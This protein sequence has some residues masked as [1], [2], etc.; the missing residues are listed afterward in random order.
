[1]W[2]KLFGMIVVSALCVA[3]PAVAQ[4]WTEVGNAGD[5]PSTA[6]VLSGAGPLTTVNGQTSFLSDDVDM[7][8][9][10][11]QG[12]GTFSA[13]AQ[14]APF[15]GL[16]LDPTLALFDAEG[17]AVYANDNMFPPDP[18]IGGDAARLPANHA[19]TPLAP[20]LYYLAIFPSYRAPI[21]SFG[22]IF[23]CIPC[24]PGIVFGPTGPGGAGAITGWS[25]SPF[26]GGT[27]RITLTGACFSADCAPSDS[28]PPT[29]VPTITGTL[30]LAGWYISDVIVSWSVNDA[31]SPVTSQS[32]CN[33]QTVSTDTAGTTFTCLA[34]SSGGTSSQSVTIK[35][36][37]TAPVLSCSA[38]PNVLWPPSG[39]LV[40]IQTSITVNDQLSGADGFVL[41][42]FATSDGETASDM[43][44]WN[45]GTSDTSGLL[46]AIRLGFTGGRSYSLFYS[47]TDNAG[48]Q[49]T[50]SV[51]I[52]VPHDQGL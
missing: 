10:F 15:P 11:L 19:L 13:V 45:L 7:F 40:P 20:G 24:T 38:N 34:T 41:E 9:I 47:S 36:D 25:G 16:H 8:A 51:T 23:P 37:T 28:T 30:G 33:S 18:F 32:G 42:S 6:Q 2:Q 39:Q 4:T 52:T 27:Y 44:D 48:N 35:R 3:P 43:V 22:E 29:I 31:Q 46:R 21:S 5:L 49:S 17:K 26:S 50:C 14:G 12:G 1:M